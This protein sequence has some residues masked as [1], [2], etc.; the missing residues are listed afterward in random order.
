MILTQIRPKR[1]TLKRALIHVGF[2]AL[3]RGAQSVSRFSKVL[4][5]EIAAWPDGY[6]IALKVNPNGPELWLQVYDRRLIRVKPKG[7]TPGLI[8][9]FKTVNTGFRIITTLTSVP[10]AFTQNRIMV[11][12]DTA[13]SMV[14]I[15]ILNIVQ[16]YLFPSILSK[17]I[18]KRVPRFG[19][20]DHLGRLRVY[21]TGILFGL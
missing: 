20:R 1:S 2:Y 10:T 9:V 5:K 7:N 18:L 11:Y 14:L 21:T 16:S 8:V 6:T 17:R 12:G 4:K 19:W 15:R 3:G 13:Q